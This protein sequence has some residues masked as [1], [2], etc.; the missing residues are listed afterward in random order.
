MSC[1]PAHTRVNVSTASHAVDSDGMVGMHMPDTGV[2]SEPLDV[3]GHARQQAENHLGP[4]NE[5]LRHVHALMPI[6]TGDAPTE[7]L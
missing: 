4:W 5:V 3:R 7:P 2:T 1:V 6:G